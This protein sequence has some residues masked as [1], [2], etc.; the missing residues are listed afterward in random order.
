[1]L[2][3]L[4]DRILIQEDQPQIYST[5]S[6]GGREGEAEPWPIANPETVDER[7][8]AVGLPPLAEHT[9]RLNAQRLQEVR[10]TQPP[11]KN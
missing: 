7:R 3:L 10:K 1:M 11:G 8:R 6:I 5:Q 2:A 4:T 9:M